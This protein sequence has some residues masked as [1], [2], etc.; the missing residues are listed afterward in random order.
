MLIRHK[1]LSFKLAK[2]VVYI[3]KKLEKCRQKV[4]MNTIGTVMERYKLLRAKHLK[5]RYEHVDQ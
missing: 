3:Y 4:H 2:V 5:I 1:F